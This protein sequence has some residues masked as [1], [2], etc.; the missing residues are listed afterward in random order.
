MLGLYLHIPFCSAICNYCN[1]NRG[2]FDAELKTR[3][4]E[5]LL[6]EIGRARGAGESADTIF[7]GGGTPSLLEPDEIARIIVACDAAFDIAADREVTLEANPESVTEARLAAYR[8]AGVKRL[9][10]G[11]QSFRDE[12]LR[13][14]SRLHSAD[15]ARAAFGEA[16]AAGF[17]NVSLDLMMWLPE[18]RVTEWLES[19]DAAIALGPDHLSLYMLEVYP[20]RAAQGRHGPRPLVAGARRRRGGRCI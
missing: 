8:D 4:V 5:A 6:T 2:L 9:S 16:R 12:E 17:D 13:R 1:F 20:E 7:F 15:R 19:V 3:Y 18:Q 11:V 10:F 14:L